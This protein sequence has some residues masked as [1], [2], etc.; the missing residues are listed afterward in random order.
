[1]SNIKSFE[2][3]NEGLNNSCPD[4]GGNTYY[5]DVLGLNKCTECEWDE[6]ADEPISE[7][8]LIDKIYELANLQHYSHIDE[9]RNSLEEIR[10]LIKE[11]YDK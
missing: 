6:P 10:D 7:N 3:F 2:T 5:E 9:M 11:H 1:M 8:E 4:C